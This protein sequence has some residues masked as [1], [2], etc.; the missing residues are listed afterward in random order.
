VRRILTIL[1]AIAVALMVGV[2][3]AA[4]DDEPLSPEAVVAKLQAV[5][6]TLLTAPDKDDA[7]AT[8]RQLMATQEDKEP[9]REWERGIGIGILLY[10]MLLAL[11]P[12]EAGEID[13]DTAIVKLEPETIEFVLV[14][15]DGQWKVDMAATYD[16][17]PEKLR[18]ALQPMAQRSSEKV[19]QAN[20]LSNLKQLTL[21]AMMYA[22]HHDEKLP[23][24]DK[25]MDQLLPYLK[26]EAI[27]RCPAA[28]DLEYGYA[29]NSA[30][31]GMA[32]EDITSPAWTVIFFD[33]DVGTRNAAGGSDAVCDPPRH[34]GGNNYAYADGHCRLEWNAPNFDPKAEAQGHGGADLVV[35]L[36]D[37]SFEAEVLRAKGWVLVDFGTDECDPCRWLKPIFHQMAREY[38]GRVKFAS[39]D[40][41]KCSEVPEDYGIGP[42]PTVILFRDGKQV[43]KQ[44][45]FGGED[46]FRAWVRG[47]VKE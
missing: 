30:L 2:P 27:Y 44:V 41:A 32:I 19:R 26:N 35:E 45:G 6:F 12:G 8:L 5:F 14:Q 22:Q 13:G 33:S 1:L 43:D 15:Q 7:K 9:G 28:L 17:M 40:V 21:G 10:G 39:V 25:W 16:R 20:C 47:H 4:Q 23:D 36:T 31:S 46:G 38:E 37:D 42:I 3:A 24:A 18:K 34:N 29:M 11:P